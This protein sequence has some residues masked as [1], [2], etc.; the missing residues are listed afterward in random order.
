MQLTLSE[1]RL[2]ATPAG[3]TVM[4]G[5][6]VSRARNAEI[7][8]EDGRHFIDFATG[9]STMNVGHSHPKVTAALH[10]QV[11]KFTHTFFQQLPYES[12]IRLS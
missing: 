4:S 11:D 3:L 12:Y 1:R 6:F 10:D 9:T 5:I 7:W 8:A 2:E